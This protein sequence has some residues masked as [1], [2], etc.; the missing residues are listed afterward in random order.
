MAARTSGISKQRYLGYQQASQN[1]YTNVAGTLLRTL[2]SEQ[3]SLRVT[4]LSLGNTEDETI[5]QVSIASACTALSQE[6]SELRLQ[7]T[8]SQRRILRYLPD[9]GL[10]ASTGLILPK[11]VNDSIVGKD[12]EL[13]LPSPQ[14]PVMLT[15]HDNVFW[16]RD[17]K[18]IEVLVEASVIDN[19]DLVALDGTYDGSAP[20]G[21]GRFFAGQVVS[22]SDSKFPSGSQVVGWQRGAHRNRLEVSAEHLRLC[23][24]NPI[25]AVAA[26]QLLV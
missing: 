3:P 10:S 18:K 25:S 9:D 7:V 6:E 12:Y 17:T 26:A 16:K 2:Q 19:E 20:P 21:L 1:P 15:S 4:W 5:I 22:E 8:D 23:D 24:G 14:K 11:V 13:A